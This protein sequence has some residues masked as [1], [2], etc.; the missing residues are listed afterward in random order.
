ML[1]V[2][3]LS[4]IQGI[5][6]FIPIS[7][8]AHLVLISQYFNFN[9]S[10][11][12]LDISLHLGSLLAI[13]TYFRQDIYNFIRNKNLFLKILISSIPTMIVGYLLVYYSLIEYLRDYKLIG[14]TTIIFG[15]LLYFSDLNQNTKI[16]KKD[17]NLK[18]AIYIG[19]FQILSLIPGVSRSGIT[20][21]GARMFNFSRVESVKISFLMSVPILA[22]VSLFNIQSL[23]LE[24]NLKFSTLNLISIFLSFFFSYLTIKL[25]LNFLKQS[26][27]T[28]FVIYRI[29]LGFIILIYAY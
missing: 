27:L 24:N 21:T 15:I 4:A 5:T 6:E 29:I 10:S 9:N 26:S 18:T 2:I 19:F 23:I 25:F 22:A 3:I 16:I 8:S 28:Y 17:Y 14:W 13:I 1:E 7:S 12:T 11:L 20:I